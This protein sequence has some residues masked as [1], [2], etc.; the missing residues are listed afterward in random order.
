[1]TI[2]YGRA[3]LVIATGSN[4]VVPAV[5]G[6]S[7]GKVLTNETVFALREKLDHL[8]IMGGGPVGVEM[9][10]AHR[11]LGV[12]VTVVQKSS[13]LPRDEPELVEILRGVL[14]REKIDLLED[15]KSRPS[16]MRRMG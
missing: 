7:A 6:L 3:D 11:R 12:A 5:P 13:I 10:L 1:M 4:P 14:R 8:L 16:G 2:P 15:R 9:A